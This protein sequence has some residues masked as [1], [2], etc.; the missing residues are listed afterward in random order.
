MNG[1]SIVKPQSKAKKNGLDLALD[2]VKA[3]RVYKAKNVDDLSKQLE[4]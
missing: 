3:G 4:S 2:D 1:V